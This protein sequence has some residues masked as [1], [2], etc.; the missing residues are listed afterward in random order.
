MTTLAAAAQMAT[1][2]ASG[3]TEHN[4][5]SLRIR[6]NTLVIGNSIYP[7]ANISRIT[8][9]DLRTPVPAFVWIML[10][11]GVLLLLTVIGAAVGV[12]L[13]AVACYMLYLNWKSK[14]AADFALSVQLNSGDT[15]VVLSNSGDFLKAIALELYEVIELEVPSNSTFNIDQSVRIDNVTRSTV[16]ITGIQGDIVQNV[17]GI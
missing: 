11:V 4:H 13:I 10:G 3:K 2:Q 6:A 5:G 16:A 1:G 14:S 9:S 8:L 17:D 15:A 12:L 7:I